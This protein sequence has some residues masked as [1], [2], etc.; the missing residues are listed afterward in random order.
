M[1]RTARSLLL[2][3]LLAGAALAA[4]GD[5][6]QATRTTDDPSADDG[7]DGDDG[8]GDVV[9]TLDHHGGFLP[10]ERAVGN[11]PDVVLL[12]DGTVLSPAP[13]IAIFP[14]PALT[15][16]QVGHLDGAAVEEVVAAVEALDPDADY[17]LPA[18]GPQVADAADTTVR[19]VRGGEVVREVTAYALGL[20]DET[21]ARSELAAVVERLGDAGAG[22]GEEVYEPTAVRVLDVTDQ[23]GD[24]PA[25]PTTVDP[26]QPGEPTGRVLDWPVAHD[27]RACTEV[28]D[29]AE[30]DAV[31]ARMAEATQLDWFATDAG[32]R[33][34]VV[35]PILPGDDAPCEADA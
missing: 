19:L 6:D 17:G 30:V 2:L 23:A 16:Y 34:L 11:T 31:L 1:R 8:G 9:L 18:G 32:E 3:A 5:D 21:G 14:G 27:G 15:P 24:P 26:L 29:A 28:T 13:V 4:C 12:G 33:R 10:V 22:T 7:G 25:S 35:V 20:G